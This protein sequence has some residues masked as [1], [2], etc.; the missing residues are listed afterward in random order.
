[1]KNQTIKPFLPGNYILNKQISRPR[2]LFGSR[3][4]LDSGADNI[5]DCAVLDRK[6]VIETID[7]R[8]LG[9]KGIH[10]PPGAR[11]WGYTFFIPDDQKDGSGNYA[12]GGF[13]TPPKS[14]EEALSVI[15]ERIIKHYSLSELK[16]WES[17]PGHYLWQHYSCEWGC[18]SVCSEVGESISSTQTHIAFCRG[19]AKQY[20][21]PWGLQFSFWQQGRINDYTGDAV[22]GVHS[23]PNGGHSPSLYKRTF[24]AAYMGGASHFYPEACAVINFC[25]ELDEDGCYKLSPVGE[26][27]RRLNRF[28]ADNR[29]I[30]INYTPFGIV[31]DYYHGM[32]SGDRQITKRKAFQVFDYNAG[33]D[34]T[35]NLFDKFFPSSWVTFGANEATYQVNGPYGDTCDVLLQNAPQEVLDSYPCLIMTGDINLSEEEKKRYAAYVKKGGTL[36]LNTAYLSFFP[37]YEAEYN[38]FRRC[39]ITDEEGTVIVYGPDYMLSGLDEILCEQLL[40]LVPFRLSEQVEYL[41]NVTEGS[42]ILTLIN[43]DGYYYNHTTG[44]MV[45]SGKEKKLTVSYTGGAQVKAVKELWTAE[46][47]PAADTLEISVPPGEAAILEFSLV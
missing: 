13:K 35:Y 29:N 16:E 32:F 43:N 27:S 3:F 34:M 4:V 31:L 28:I 30:G 22:W 14:R 23:K 45:D 5:W 47:F 24:L 25:K 19:A 39:D 12:M 42:L 6:K 38:G 33:D 21:I 11:E 9:E 41:V 46:V 37:E 44:E 8:Q 36:I 17:C 26:M 40:R 2:Y 20:K 10:C 18:T 1:M 15:R 7:R